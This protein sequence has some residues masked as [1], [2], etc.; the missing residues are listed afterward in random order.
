MHKTISYGLMLILTFLAYSINSWGSEPLPQLFYSYAGMTQ[1]E[2]N[3]TIPSKDVPVA[4]EHQPA[5][6][7]TEPVVQPVVKQ[8]PKSRK[9]HKPV[10][11]NPKVNVPPTKIIKPKI[12]IKKISVSVP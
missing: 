12:V 4:Q 8:V 11:V 10:A 7:N 3:D 6:T 9:K 2:V 1:H 5:A